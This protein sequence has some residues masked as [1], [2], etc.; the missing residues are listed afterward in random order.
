MEKTPLQVATA[1]AKL[2]ALPSSCP[3]ATKVMPEA[4][5]AVHAV[6][7]RKAFAS[8]LPIALLNAFNTNNRINQYL[9]DH[10]PPAA[11]KAKTANGKG[12]TIPSILAHMHNVRV[13]WL[14][15][16]AKGS[17]IPAQLDRAKVT[18]SQALHA[19]ER[20]RHALSLVM[21]GALQD[22]GRVRGFRP[23][24]AG[25]VAYLIAHDAHHRGQIAMLARQFGHPLPQKAMFGMWEW[26]RR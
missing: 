20:S 14:K 21:I 19:L 17:K 25:F 4:P 23:D 13:M 11:W 2:K 18:P 6:S 24:V 26:G 3:R 8:E 7:R 10:I 15:M 1:Y 22:D 5:S 9:I 16:A 12:R